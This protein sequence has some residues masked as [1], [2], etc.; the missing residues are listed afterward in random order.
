MEPL[1]G[2]ALFDTVVAVVQG[3]PAPFRHAGPLRAMVKALLAKEPVDRPTAEQTNL[4][5]VNVELGFINT[6][7]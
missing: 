4:A 6:R 2:T 3:A 5:L 1:F 7:V